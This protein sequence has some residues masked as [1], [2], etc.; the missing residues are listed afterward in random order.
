MA[1]RC[2]SRWKGEIQRVFDFTDSVPIDRGKIMGRVF[3]SK[4]L[5]A[6]RRLKAGIE[7]LLRQKGYDPDIKVLNA[8]KPGLS[9]LH[10]EILPEL[11][12]LPSLHMM[13]FGYQPFA[14]AEAGLEMKSRWLQELFPG[15]E[16]VARSLGLD[17]NRVTI[18]RRAAKRRPTKSLAWTRRERSFSDPSFHR[19][20]HH[21]LTCPRSLSWVSS[22]PRQ[23]Q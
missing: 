18:S 15:P 11:R 21:S 14:T 10:E 7:R 23:A 8:Y 17:R 9:W 2:H 5:P 22:T 12:K 6:S 1:L 20:G 4:P 3:V 13:K 16:L 19:S